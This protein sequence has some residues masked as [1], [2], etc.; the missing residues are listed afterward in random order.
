[1]HALSTCACTM[2]LVH[3]KAHEKLILPFTLLLMCFILSS[4]LTEREQPQL[5]GYF[6]H[7][8]KLKAELIG[9]IAATE[10]TEFKC[11]MLLFLKGKQ[12]EHK[13]V[14]SVWAHICF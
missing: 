12:S 4:E 1:M 5:A 14:N 13:Y 7:S 8:C 9:L 3:R 6:Q 10:G 11:S 2:I